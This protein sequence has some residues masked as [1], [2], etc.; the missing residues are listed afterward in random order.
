MAKLF[1][2]DYIQIIERT[3]AGET[4]ASIADDLPVDRRRVSKIICDF[5][6]GSESN[7]L[8]KL[9]ADFL[10]D[11]VRQKLKKSMQIGRSRK[12]QFIEYAQKNS[13]TKEEYDL[14]MK[15]WQH[16]YETG[17]NLGRGKS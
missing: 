9:M 17:Y 11:S 4:R 8:K 10:T 5:V 15:A 14:L 6:D 2:K 16:G 7:N 12:H 13:K 3:I 1:K